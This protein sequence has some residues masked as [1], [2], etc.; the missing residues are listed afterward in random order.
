MIPFLT[1]DLTIGLTVLLAIWSTYNNM[2]VVAKTVRD[3]LTL[4]GKTF[5]DVVYLVPL[6]AYTTV[7]CFITFIVVWCIPSLIIWFF[8]GV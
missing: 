2:D 6:F 1:F 7:L 5:H 8:F 4:L 3:R